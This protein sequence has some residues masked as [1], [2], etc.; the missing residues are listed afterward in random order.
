MLGPVHVNAFSGILPMRYLIRWMTICLAFWIITLYFDS[1]IYNFYN[2][3]TILWRAAIVFFSGYPRQFL[4]YFF[5]SFINMPTKNNC[6]RAIK[7]HFGTVTFHMLTTEKY[8]FLRDRSYI[9]LLETN[10]FQ[11]SAPEISYS[12]HFNK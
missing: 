12:R 4:F 1:F 9:D 10:F 2:N 3:S 8:Q 11:D 5:L 7:W 6:E